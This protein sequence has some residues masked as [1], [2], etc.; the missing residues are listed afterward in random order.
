MLSLL[1]FNFVSKL[2]IFIVSSSLRTFI[3]HLKT[4]IGFQIVEFNFA[5]QTIFCTILFLQFL[6]DKNCV[7]CAEPIT[8]P[9][10]KSRHLLSLS[11]YLSDHDV[12]LRRSCG[13]KG[14]LDRIGSQE[15]DQDMLICQNHV[16]NQQVTIFQRQQLKGLLLNISI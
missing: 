13:Y 6:S 11:C 2:S 9:D 4:Q 5:V 3:W 14:T 8:C 12:T 10:R 7:S 1:K 16:T 15:A